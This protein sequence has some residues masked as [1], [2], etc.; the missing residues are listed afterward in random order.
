MD[1]C[2]I[3]YWARRFDP[4][5]SNRWPILSR[6]AVLLKATAYPLICRV[7]SILNSG[8]IQLKCGTLFPSSC[9]F[10]LLSAQG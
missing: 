3:S 8:L 4:W 6:L 9:S 1:F 5:E 7:G 10:F 2:T